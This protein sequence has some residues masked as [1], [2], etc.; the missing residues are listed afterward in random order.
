MAPGGSSSSP[1]WRRSS[2]GGTA[3]A[4]QP[5]QSSPPAG[6]PRHRRVSARHRYSRRGP[7]LEGHRAE[8]AVE[9]GHDVE[10]ST[11]ALLRGHRELLRDHHLRHAQRL[12]HLGGAGGFMG[13]EEPYTAERTKALP[14]DSC[15]SVTSWESDSGGTGVIQS[16]GAAV[17]RPVLAS[18]SPV[19]RPARRNG[20]NRT[21]CI[22][23]YSGR[24]SES[25]SYSTVLSLVLHGYKLQWHVVI[26][27]SGI[28]MLIR[29]NK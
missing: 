14:P 23:A 12:E 25:F 2:S 3:A 7:E 20:P 19:V 16:E 21:A 24:S 26:Q 4:A 15:T 17:A 29:V 18:Q 11:Q 28:S 9:P 1:P 8:R 27:L 6:T 22:H 13:D 5:A 10:Q